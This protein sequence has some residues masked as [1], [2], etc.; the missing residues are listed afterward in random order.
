MRTGDGDVLQRKLIRKM[1]KF[2]CSR[3][4]KEVGGIIIVMLM[5]VV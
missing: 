4:E 3:I 1:Q 2:E 5:L